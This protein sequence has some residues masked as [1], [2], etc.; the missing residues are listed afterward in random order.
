M[1]GYFQTILTFDHNKKTVFDISVGDIKEPERE[2][3]N[4]SVSVDHFWA[5]LTKEIIGRRLIPSSKK[6]Y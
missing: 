3:A 6:H 5:N 4:D 1:Y 2:T